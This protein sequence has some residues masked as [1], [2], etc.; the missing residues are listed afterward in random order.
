MINI[1]RDSIL[2]LAPEIFK[3]IRKVFWNTTYA[4]KAIHQRLN[5]HQRWDDHKR[6]M[7]S[8]TTY[9]LIRWWR[10]LWYIIDTEPSSAD[11]DLQ[12]LLTIYL[13]SKK[14]DITE[15]QKK[16]GL[17]VPKVL[18]RIQTVKTSR[19]LRESLPDWLDARGEKELGSR[20][21]RV[22]S[23][24]NTNPNLTIRVNTLKTTGKDLSIVLRKQGIIAESINGTSDALII[25][26]KTNVFR[27]PSFKTGLFEV[28]DVASQMVSRILNPQPSMRVIDACAG[29]G[30]KTLHLASLMKN[31]GKIIALDT[32][33]WRLKQLRKRAVKAGAD[34]IETRL[35][36]SSKIY[37]R[38][39]GT[40]DK[41]LLDV[42]CSGLGTL[43]RN[44]DIK[45]KLT[46]TDLDRLQNLQYE[47][48]ERYSPLIKVKATMV[49]SVCSILPSEGEE[50]IQR[51]LKN[52]EPFRLLKEKRYWPD[53][54]GT[55][56]FYIAYMERIF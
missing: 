24:L 34:T 11:E 21:D 33:E 23:S 15:L 45:W 18:Q 30:S 4:T 14:G 48:L 38:M 27:L 41:L 13:F 1:V 5:D 17:D 8:E 35:I 51:F 28:Q 44:P 56:G 25:K 36:S 6:G 19:V 55:D 10:P 47:L 53:T 50:Q 46:A 32:Q 26:E 29:E 22:I 3:A 54:D 2:E 31:K 7:F 37:K 40:A 16:K 39:K 20:W 52:H 12:K 43:R 9:D 49:Y 42:P